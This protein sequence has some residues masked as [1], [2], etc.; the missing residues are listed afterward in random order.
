MINQISGDIFGRV[1]QY[2]PENSQ[3]ISR[4]STEEIFVPELMGI[5]FQSWQE[6]H[7][8]ILRLIL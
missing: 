8:E 6:D 4:R 1:N 3:I 5:I 7:G 2:L